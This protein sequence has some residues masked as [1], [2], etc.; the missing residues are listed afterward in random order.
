MPQILGDGILPRAC[1]LVVYGKEKTRKSF[2]SMQLCKCVGRGENFLGIETTKGRSMYLQ[3]ELSPAAVQ[4][5]MKVDW[6]DGYVCNV[7]SLKLDQK[8]GIKNFLDTVC[9]IGPDLVVI[10]PLYKVLSGD[11]NDASAVQ[12]VLD[13]LDEAIECTGASIVVIHHEN[14]EGR[15]Q[16]SGR[17]LQWP[18]GILRMRKKDKDGPCH[19]LQFEAMRH[20]V[21]TPKD[22]SL[23][24]NN[25][26][27]GFDV[28][29]EMSLKEKVVGYL[30]E[31]GDVE[32]LKGRFPK[33][34]QVTLR[35]DRKSVV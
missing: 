12:T 24:F 8:D 4:M 13:V 3:S 16:G 30:E 5:R 20:C 2:L 11:L 7:Y 31:T 19:T 35:S 34:N 15:I 26:T 10:D 9:E 21:Q 29:D 27:N 32:G 28:S 22:I 18:D 33:E 1:K 23:V 17:I 25:M 14:R 6:M